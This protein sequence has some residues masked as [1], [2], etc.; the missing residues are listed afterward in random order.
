MTSIKSIKEKYLGEL[1]NGP[2]DAFQNDSK[3]GRNADSD[4]YTFY[5]SNG[6]PGIYHR[7]HFLS[8]K[9]A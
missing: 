6:H 9:I 5:G 2:K 4:V 8:N 7:D 3:N 1:S